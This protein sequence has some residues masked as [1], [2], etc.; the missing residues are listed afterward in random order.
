MG[1][2]KPLDSQFLL[3]DIT[4]LR[5]QGGDVIVSFGGQNPTELALVP[6]DVPTLQAQ[7]QAVIDAYSLTAIDFDIEEAA[8][9]DAHSVDRRNA[10]IAGLQ[11]AAQA[12]GRDLAVSYT[13]PVDPA[14]L[15]AEG[16]A[17]LRN[18]VKR[19]VNVALVNIMTMDFD[20]G[21]V[22]PDR[23]GAT[24]IQATRAVFGQ[25]QN[26]LS[27]AS[28]AT[29]GVTP[30]IGV[31]DI[32]KEVFTLQDAH[33]LLAFARQ[34]GLGRL[35]MWEVNRDKSCPPNGP[36]GV[37]QNTCSGVD[38]QPFDFTNIFKTISG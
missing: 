12:G 26:L 29:I 35:A 2:V 31:N 7:Y 27:G 17:V 9:K 19:G 32:V 14:G 6:G 16:L 37:A 5:A 13:L 33:D 28:W 10:A 25:L 21:S 30:M 24:A 1:G 18:A 3:S 15:T 34:N 23:M 22:P 8:I 38:Q 36:S 11:S 4:D 20:E